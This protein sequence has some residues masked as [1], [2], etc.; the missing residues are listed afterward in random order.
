MRCM[1]RH[2]LRRVRASEHV[3]HSPAGDHSSHQF[4]VPATSEIYTLSLHDAL[5]I[6]LA[7]RESPY[8]R[9]R[10]AAPARPRAVLSSGADRKS[11]RLNSSH[12]T[13]SYA[14]FCCKQKHNPLASA[15]RVSGKNPV[16]LLPHEP[17]QL[18]TG[19]LI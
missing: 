11:T 6:S 10:P 4:T 14:V 3:E 2:V 19:P 9:A 16:A 5:P 12:R 17:Q 13:D 8:A 18:L 1:F 7:L 15:H